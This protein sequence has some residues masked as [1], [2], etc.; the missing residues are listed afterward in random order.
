[1]YSLIDC[2]VHYQAVKRING[3]ILKWQS[4][5][6]TEQRTAGHSQQRTH[7][8][9]KNKEPEEPAEMTELSEKMDSES[10]V[11]SPRSMNKVPVRHLRAPVGPR[12]KLYMGKKTN[13]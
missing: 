13:L 12:R 9:K 3:I 8:K 11:L 2:T 4:E 6:H 7:H 10:D 1:M 5:I